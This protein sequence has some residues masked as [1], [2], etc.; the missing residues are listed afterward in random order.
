MALAQLP[1]DP[2]YYKNG[3]PNF[4][5]DVNSVVGANPG[6]SPNISYDT[7]DLSNLFGT[8][9]NNKPVGTAT[10]ANPNYDPTAAALGNMI[11]SNQANADTLNWQYGNFNSNLPGYEGQQIG[12]A[13]DVSKYNLA[14]D[15][16]GVNRSTNA[17]GL[18]QSGL[19]SQG[20]S[21]AA[22]TEGS[23]LAG[24]IQN[25]NQQAEAQNQGLLN[26]ATSAQNNVDQEAIQYQGVLAADKQNAYSNALTNQ[27][28]QNNWLGSMFAG[29]GNAVG[30]V[31]GAIF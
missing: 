21:Q 8:G 28:N 31:L 15:I 20:Q 11:N 13:T 26:Q 27:Q 9:S 1:T 4:S 2:S 19:T 16:M 3:M 29:V 10:I 7:Y 25:I 12:A 14:N 6:G 23:Q 30:G 24:N 22:A 5:G 17:R 18:L